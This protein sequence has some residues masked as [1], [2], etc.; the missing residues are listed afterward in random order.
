[1]GGVCLAFLMWS[2]AKQD[3]RE[4]VRVK[5]HELRMAGIEA[6]ANRTTRAILLLVISLKS[7][8]EAA[9][10]EARGI[11]REIELAEGKEQE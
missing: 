8:S 6:A 11:V 7:A 5:E 2:R 9:K 1:M 10:T 3:E 4:A